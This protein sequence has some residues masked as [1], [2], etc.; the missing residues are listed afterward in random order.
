M[1]V[2]YFVT[3][4]D[5]FLVDVYEVSLIALEWLSFLPFK[6]EVILNHDKL[7]LAQTFLKH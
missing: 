3:E 5:Q 7:W 6:Y 4:E 1:C 2:F